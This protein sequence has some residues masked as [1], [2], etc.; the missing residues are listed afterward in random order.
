MW[1]FR[2][3]TTAKHLIGPVVAA[4]L[5]PVETGTGPNDEDTV[6]MM[7]ETMRAGWW[8]CRRAVEEKLKEAA[9]SCS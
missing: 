4:E 8:R 7:W 2:F 3:C 9:E 5:D 6:A 1:Y